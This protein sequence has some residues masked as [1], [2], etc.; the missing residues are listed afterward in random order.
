MADV[1]KLT[2]CCYSLIPLSFLCCLPP[3]LPSFHHQQQP[4]PTAHRTLPLHT[5]FSPLIAPPLVPS[6]I[7]PL[8]CPPLNPVAL[9]VRTR[10]FLFSADPIILHPNTIAFSLPSSPGDVAHVA[11]TCSLVRHERHRN[12]KQYALAG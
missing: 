8:L 2:F 3:R 9:R 6:L 1:Q 12:P 5:Q 11:R 7:P 10:I 4:S